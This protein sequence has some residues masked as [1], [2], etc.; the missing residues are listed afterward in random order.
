MTRNA[1]IP[2]GFTGFSTTQKSRLPFDGN[3]KR[4]QIHLPMLFLM[5]E[6]EDRFV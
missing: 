2:Y 5:V 1:E 4:L 3:V 6:S